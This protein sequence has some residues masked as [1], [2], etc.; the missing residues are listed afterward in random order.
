MKAWHFVGDELRNGDAVPEDGVKLVYSG[1]IK[2]CSSGL[3][4]SERIIDALAY[5]R[6]ATIC[7]VECS[8][9]MLV[10]SDKLVCTE[11][12]ILWRI[13]G[14]HLLSEFARKQALGVGH[15]WNIPDVVR[16]YLETGDENIRSAAQDAAWFATR[17]ATWSATR[18]AAWAAAQAAAWA[19]AQ[20]AAWAATRAATRAAAWSATQDAA[21]SAT[22]SAT[23]AAAWA[24]A[25]N[26]LEER[27][28]DAAKVIKHLKDLDL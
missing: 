19:A 18:A 17:D 2:L 15:L 22:W 10:E 3:H 20:D 8:G 27:V 26:M 7:R 21:W 5:A 28:T 1:R 25:N 6:G 13:D 9:E 11:R 16:R 14:K 12:T 24:A 23:R 4:A